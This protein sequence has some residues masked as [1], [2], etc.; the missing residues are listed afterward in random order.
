MEL[1][2]RLHYLLDQLSS[3][4]ATIAEM[5]ELKLL[6]EQDDTDQSI[7]Y[8][9]DQL[10]MNTPFD[11]VPFNREKWM[12]VADMIINADKVS[13][14][15]NEPTVLQTRK[16]FIGWRGIRRIAAAAILLA[17]LSTFYWLMNRHSA[18]PTIVKVSAEN[19]VEPGRSGAKLTLA[20]GSI[21]VLDSAGNGVVA[22]QKGTSVLL[23][24]G[25]LRYDA[26][27]ASQAALN[28][29]E[30]PR[31]RQFHVQLPD[32]TRVWLNSGSSITYPTFFTGPERRVSMKGEAYFDVA[33]NAA[34]PFR[35][36]VT[37]EAEVNVLG[38]QFN[39]NAYKDDGSINT[40]LIEGAVELQKI[41][42]KPGENFSKHALKLKPGQQAKLTDELQLVSNPDISK[43][44]AW[45]N[46]LFNFEGATLIEAMKQLER[47]YDIEVI[48]PAKIPDFTFFGELSQSTSMEG[49]IRALE[50]SGLHFRMDGR[51]LI[52]E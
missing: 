51:K 11:P 22:Q 29:L 8:A 17:V 14:V 15:N 4:S 42:G 49:M 21:L 25:S 40:T 43:V 23:H 2:T 13:A 38:T 36:S 16:F 34:K 3:Q 33:K 47:W 30:T 20:D 32:G 35:V 50:K 44:L 7:G 48:Y 19:K 28:T 18:R 24:N 10:V 6:L 39:V 26:A 52:I 45:K 1:N 46:G 31:G 37:D 5:D 12:Q 9:E 41:T 27:L